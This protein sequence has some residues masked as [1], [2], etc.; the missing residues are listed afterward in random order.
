MSRSRRWRH[1]DMTGM[2]MPRWSLTVMSKMVYLHTLVL[3]SCELEWVSRY[4]CYIISDKLYYWSCLSARALGFVGCVPTVT[5]LCLNKNKFEDY[6]TT[7]CVSVDTSAWLKCSMTTVHVDF[8]SLFPRHHI[9]QSPRESFLCTIK[10]WQWNYWIQKTNCIKESVLKVG[11]LSS[12][13]NIYHLVIQIFRWD[14]SGWNCKYSNRRGWGS[15]SRYKSSLI[16]KTNLNLNC[17][18]FK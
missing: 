10:W 4:L 17:D 18:W 12:W 5:T 11:W 9:P 13:I 6:V 14:S 3:D 15:V 2:K 8:I 16:I 7:S 1:I